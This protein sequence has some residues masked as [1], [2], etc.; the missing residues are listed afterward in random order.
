VTLPVAALSV[1]PSGIVIAVE[2][3]IDA[4]FPTVAGVQLA[5]LE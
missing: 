3:T 1:Q 5:I 2:L 4:L